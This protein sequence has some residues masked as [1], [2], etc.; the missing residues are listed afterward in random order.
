VRHERLSS[1]IPGANYK[2]TGTSLGA[3]FTF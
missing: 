2:N 3:K 1:N